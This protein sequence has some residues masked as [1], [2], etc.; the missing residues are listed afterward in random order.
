V[1]ATV[2]A[3]TDATFDDDVLAQDKPILV[4]FWAEWCGPCRIMSPML[5]TLA[6][7]Q[8][9]RVI[10]VKVNVDENPKTTARY[11]VMSLPA[12]H[13]FNRGQVVKSIVGFKPKSVLLREID[14]VFQAVEG[15]DAVRAP[16]EG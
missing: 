14:E 10:V 13:I 7:E 4:D 8:A 15:G 2:R 5:E 1:E 11:G 12:I 3:V 6:Q 16:G 9:Q